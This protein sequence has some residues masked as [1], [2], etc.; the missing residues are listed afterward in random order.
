MRIAAAMVLLL[1][2]WCGAGNAAAHGIAVPGRHWVT[3]GCGFQGSRYGEGQFCTLGCRFGV[4]TM[5]VCHGGRWEIEP[6]AC[7]SSFGCSRFC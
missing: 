7:R 3:R 5:Q 1:C 2:V 6:A 4:C